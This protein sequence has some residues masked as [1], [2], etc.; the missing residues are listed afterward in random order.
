MTA[1]ALLLAIVS[2]GFAAGLA[3]DPDDPPVRAP[4]AGPDRLALK[5]PGVAPVLTARDA[6]VISLR[7]GAGVPASLQEEGRPIGRA[8][9]HWVVPATPSEDALDVALRW[10]RDPAV[11]AAIPDLLLRPRA[12]S[13]DDPVYP[14]QWYMESYGMEPLFERSL[15]DPDVWI[16]VI[17]SAVEIGHPDLVDA[18]VA[19]FDAVDDDDDPSPVP[20]EDCTDGSQG[21]CD[22]HGTSVSGISTARANNG[23]GI[24]GFCPQCSLV[25][26]RMLGDGAP[27]S[28]EIAAFEHAIEQD[29]AVINN[30]WG[31]IEAIPAPTAL[32]EVIA[33]ASTDSRGGLGALVVFASG[34]DNRVVGD[35]E[36]GALPGVLSVS[37]IDS[38]GLPAPF[39]NTGAS[40][41]V[42]APSATVTL[43]TSGGTTETFGGTSAAAPVVSGLAGWIVS[44]DPTLSA[45]EVEALLVETARKTSVVTF[46]AQ[47]HHD[48]YGYGIIDPGAILARLEGEDAS[49]VDEQPKGCGCASTGPS[50]GWL[51]GLVA[52][53]AMS[54]RRRPWL[55]LLGLA[56][57][58]PDIRGPDYAAWDS[59]AAASGSRVTNEDEGDGVTS[60]VVDAADPAVWVHVDFDDGA[61]EVTEDDAGWDL[62]FSRQR[63]ATN[64]GVSG[65]EGVEVAIVEAPTLDDVRAA[66]TDGYLADQPDDDD[67]NGDAEY[68]FDAWF[69]Y[70]STTHVLTPH[71]RVFV[72]RT[73][74]DA[75]VAIEVLSYYDD[76]GSS[77][78]MQLRWKTLRAR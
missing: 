58:W 66:P 21:L 39:T 52:L 48:T 59:D 22:T 31:Y 24:V 18:V 9:R 11:E 72:V 44:M 65:T 26:I 1:S 27:L 6:A 30:S 29:A 40:V 13:F 51:A 15:G 50:S 78:L 75:Y 77:G 12:A 69:D 41:D 47:G 35:D 20:G 8:A 17:D 32:A 45:D 56:G 16:A 60:T 64:G 76:A 14:G 25:P 43:T 68:V 67:D 62:M 74:G 34:N 2:R 4:G 71:D 33:R 36:L 3:V 10:A 54:A 53:A 63:I 46:D 5:F 55:A 23:V 37:A 49:P 70:D 19:P 7:P 28:V 73:T 57:C 42:A 61:A 38:Y